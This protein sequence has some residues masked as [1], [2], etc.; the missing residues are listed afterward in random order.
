MVLYFNLYRFPETRNVR[1][2]VST[3]ILRMLLKQGKYKNYGVFLLFE[4]TFQKHFIHLAAPKHTT[5]RNTWVISFPEFSN[6][7]HGHII[8]IWLTLEFNLPKTFIRNEFYHDYIIQDK[9]RYT[10]VG[11]I[12]WLFK[13][14]CFTRCGA[15]CTVVGWGTMLQAESHWIQSK[16]LIQR[17]NLSELQP[18]RLVPGGAAIAWPRLD[19]SIR[20]QLRWSELTAILYLEFQT[21][22]SHNM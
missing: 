7:T 16:F 2:K 5:K 3:Q 4:R 9:Y 11:E 18:S 10:F 20:R 14:C 22:W 13:I 12:F 21:F 19:M 17:N 6:A 1:N 15:R 8:K